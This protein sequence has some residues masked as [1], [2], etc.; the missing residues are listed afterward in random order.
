[1]LEQARWLYG[2]SETGPRSPQ[3]IVPLGYGSCPGHLAE[4]T[5]WGILEAISFAQKFPQSII[6]FGN[7]SHCFQ[8]SEQFELDEKIA[9][10]KAAR[11]SEHRYLSAGPIVNTVVE[12]KAVQAALKQHGVEAGEILFICDVAHSRSVRWIAK[13][14]FPGVRISIRYTPVV[15]YQSDHVFPAQ[16]SGWAW[17]LANLKRDV[18]L[19]AP[20]LGLE[21][22]ANYVHK[23]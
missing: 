17:M 23:R 19:R 16:Q 18:A 1:M 3:V 5:M 20:F 11:F 4:A 12:L 14:L 2:T 10:F 22:V 6:V 13:G 7:S 15:P 8:A 21:F 9:L